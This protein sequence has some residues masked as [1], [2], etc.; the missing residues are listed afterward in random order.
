[1]VIV[2]GNI[3]ADV[4]VHGLDLFVIGSGTHIQAVQDL[5]N[6]GIQLGFLLGS[7]IISIVIGDGPVI[8]IAGGLGTGGAGTPFAV[9]PHDIVTLGGNT[10]V[11][12]RLGGD[13]MDQRTEAIFVI[14][15]GP[16]LNLA[17]L[18]PGLD[19]AAK[20]GCCRGNV[21]GICQGCLGG[22][23]QGLICFG[24]IKR[25]VIMVCNVDG[26]ILRSPDRLGEEGNC[27]DQ[28]QNQGNNFTDCI[29]KHN[30]HFVCTYY[31]NKRMEMQGKSFL[32]ALNM[33][34]VIEKF[35]NPEKREKYIGK[36]KEL[37]GNKVKIC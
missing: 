25:I 5:L 26:L 31:I 29:H 35:R 24:I 22:G 15:I 28:N 21:S 37:T 3:V 17:I 16:D 19:G 2:I 13:G 23:I 34:N 9:L 1:M 36:N 14:T 33:S 7:G 11:N 4:L 18:I 27:Q 10:G 30:L 32:T 8:C 20:L 6:F 12:F